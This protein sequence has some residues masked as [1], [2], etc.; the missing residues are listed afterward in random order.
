VLSQSSISLLYGYLIDAGSSW[1][2]AAGISVSYVFRKFDAGE[3]VFRSD[4]LN[5]LGYAY[6]PVTLES[7]AKIT[8]F[9]VGP[10][11]RYTTI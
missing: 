9:S 1:Q 4:I 11:A 8:G 5:D 10:M 6:S 7:Y 3:L 2:V